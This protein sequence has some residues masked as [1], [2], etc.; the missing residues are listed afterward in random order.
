MT[1]RCCY[2]VASKQR[3][4]L[5]VSVKNKKREIDALTDYDC[6]MPASLGKVK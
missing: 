1:E 5:R 3:A 2:A 4:G 6:D